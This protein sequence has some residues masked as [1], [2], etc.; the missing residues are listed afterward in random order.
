MHGKRKD[1]TNVPGIRALPY[2]SD[3][4]LTQHPEPE[5]LLPAVRAHTDQRDVWI[6]STAQSPV[7]GYTWIDGYRASP[8]PHMDKVQ[9]CQE[10]QL[11]GSAP[12]AG[13][14]VEQCWYSTVI[15]QPDSEELCSPVT[16]VN[17]ELTFKP[18]YINTAVSC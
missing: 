16:C 1:V 8:V 2:P 13:G 12:G 5:Q 14:D 6:H 18:N 3:H 17:R 4:K 9:V 11:S 15:S 7:Y 10:E